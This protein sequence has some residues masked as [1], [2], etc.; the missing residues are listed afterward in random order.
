[1]TQPT[2]PTA[3]EADAL[4]N[5]G[6]AAS[7]SGDAQAAIHLFARASAA[8]PSSA[9]P[10]FLIG[11]EYAALGQIEDAEAA[12]A[13]AVLLAPA[14]HVA[15]YQLGL[16]QFSSGRAAAALVTWGPL[17]ALP[18]EDPL[19]HFVRGFA[20]LAQDD[21]TQARSQFD[22]GLACEQPNAAVAADIRQVLTRMQEAAPAKEGAAVPASPVA[23]SASNHV[24]VSNYG[25]FGS[26]H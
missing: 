5:A 1:M 10:H 15:R 19:P 23:E 24:L 8:A 13:N 16:L 20:A 17:L 3:H 11:S 12:L 9:A 18:A 21:F 6:L 26:L 25:R 22:A 4:L 2:P 7:Q 14:L